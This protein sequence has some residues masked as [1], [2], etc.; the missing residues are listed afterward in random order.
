MN[1]TRIDASEPDDSEP[2]ELDAWVAAGFDR[3][4]AQVWRSWRFTIA[5]AEGWLQQGVTEGL[6]AA[7]WMA[8]GVE[9][10]T[11]QEWV[12]ADI[13]APEAA[14]WHEMDYDLAGAK[15]EKAKGLGPTEAFQQAQQAQR[16]QSMGNI[17]YPSFTS[18][19]RIARGGTAR[20]GQG[21]PDPR[22][23]QSY[24][25]RQWVDEEAMEWASQ[26]ID[27][28]DAYT[29]HALGLTPVE[30]GRLAIQG[31]GPGDV[32]REWWR[33]G[34]PFEEVADWI[35]AGL[36]SKE[37]REQ[38][39]Q[40]I[41]AE[42]AGA[43][44]ALRQQEPGPK[45]DPSVLGQLITPQG[46]SGT[47][48]PGPPPEDESAARSAIEDAYSRM[49]DV[50]ETDGSIPAVDGGAKLGDVLRAAGQRHGVDQDPT[51]NSVTVDG[52]RFVND[53]EA[54]VVYSLT[55]SGPFGNNPTIKGRPGRALLVNGQ[56][57]VARDTFSALMQ[58]AGLTL[59]PREQE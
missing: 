36:S 33:T 57:R 39:A 59:P 55:I 32:I 31:R 53:R 42:Q 7:Q 49:L 11:V 35:G 18:Q 38:R 54:R 37:A 21:G 14:Q 23:L 15:A 43:L 44:R 13:D 12:D 34:I 22:V 30:A 3:R 29:W 9:P 58:M 6:H 8:A 10:T 47:A 27:A 20:M 45:Q 17:A 26:G 19:V 5:R 50:D 16:A 28:A 25:R 48:V 24:H 46:P 2:E 41:T 52:L 56:W 4:D 51:R 40:G 1:R